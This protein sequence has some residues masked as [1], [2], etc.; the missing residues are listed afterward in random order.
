MRLVFVHGWSV[1]HTNNYGDF[2]KSLQVE[3]RQRGLD[4][5]IDHIHLGK[6]I[7]F[8]DDVTMDD[9]ARA[10][11][12]ALREL[13]APGED[14]AEFSCITHSTG[15]PV[16]RYWLERFY[17]AAG[18]SRSPLR[19]LVML[20]P[21]N[22]GSSLAI[23]GKQR[24][25]RLKAWFNDVEP[26]Q[27][28]LDWLV[29]GSD[30]QQQLNEAF[31]RYKPGR[32]AFYPFVITGQGI[33]TSFYDFLNSYLVENG[34][35][36]VIR[37]AGANLNYRYLNLLQSDQP[38]DGAPQGTRLLPPKQAVRV[39]PR[40]P[41]AVLHDASHSGRK[42]GILSAGKKREVHQRTVSSVV[43]C[44]LVNDASAY[45]QLAKSFA[46]LSREQ[47]QLTPKGKDQPIDRYSMLVV[48]VSDQFG[49]PIASGDFDV[50]LL[51]GPDY[52]P[53]Q[54][55]KGF[56]VDRQ[57]NPNSHALVYYLNADRMKALQNGFGLRAVVRPES[58]FAYFDH[59]EFRSEG[60]AVDKVFAPNETTYVNITMQRRVDKNVFRFSPAK[61][62][63][64]NFKRTRPSG[65]DV[66]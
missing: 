36:G 58:G 57:L 31:L 22:H 17:G 9:I 38:V 53:D 42:M 33:D 43:D 18:L 35:D 48:R 50:L 27:Q 63:A 5:S 29:L 13:A 24:I 28:V 16:V 15:G 26:G 20:A 7:S 37:V 25:G 45:Q 10:L 54:L 3:A 40:T 64:E 2:P 55:P 4:L 46:Q 62:K 6:Y 41:L 19:H 32:G 49:T 59:A 65:E 47:Q 23:I 21:A 51:G 60:L 66:N 34:S 14:I 52:Q 11:D 12:F 61:G 1:T 39:A 8:D 30:G 44:L 56:F